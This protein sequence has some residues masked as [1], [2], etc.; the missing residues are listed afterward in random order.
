[1]FPAYTG[2]CTDRL[3]RFMCKVPHLVRG[4]RTNVSDLSVRRRLAGRGQQSRHQPI[5]DLI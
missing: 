2:D 3:L 1:M 5:V 4:L